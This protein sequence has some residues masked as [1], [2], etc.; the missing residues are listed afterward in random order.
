M[1]VQGGTC[2]HIK[3]KHTN[4]QAGKQG[5]FY[6]FLSEYFKQKKQEVIILKRIITS[7]SF[8]VFFPKSTKTKKNQAASGNHSNSATRLM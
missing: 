3:K 8:A 2:R 5:A 1:S 4:R 7:D 6:H